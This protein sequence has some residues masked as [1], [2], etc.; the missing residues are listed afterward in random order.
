MGYRNRSREAALQALFSMDMAGK[1]SSESFSL[2]CD[3]FKPAK[4]S[5]DFFHILTEGVMAHWEE[6][7]QVISTFSVNWKINRMSLVDRNILRIA[8]FEMT[9]L[10]DIPY[11]VSINEAVNMGKKYGAS[12]SGA[13][14]NGILDSIRSQY[15]KKEQN[16]NLKHQ[17]CQIEDSQPDKA[18]VEPKQAK[19]SSNNQGGENGSQKSTF[20]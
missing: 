19:K 9:Y 7:N 6:I 5:L 14:V 2:F 20:G 18:K 10:P 8:I 16:L 13:F 15:E 12:D 1:I 11:K 4:K 3:H 17:S